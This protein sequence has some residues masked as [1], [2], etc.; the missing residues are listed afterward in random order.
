MPG[1]HDMT[2]EKNSQSKNQHGIEFML[3]AWAFEIDLKA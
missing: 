1:Y 3:V 2:Y